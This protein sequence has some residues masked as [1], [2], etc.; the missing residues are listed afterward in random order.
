VF[1]MA[2]LIWAIDLTIIAVVRNRYK[3]KRRAK[4]KRLYLKSDT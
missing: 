2:N 3:K 1:E 4:A